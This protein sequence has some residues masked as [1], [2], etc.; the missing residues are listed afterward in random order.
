VRPKR[1]TLFARVPTVLR[2]GRKSHQW[3]T[4]GCHAIRGGLLALLVDLSGATSYDR[5]MHR[6]VDV[7]RVHDL[8]ESHGFRNT[9]LR[10]TFASVWVKDAR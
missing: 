1:S 5:P 6:A 7:H 10:H 4:A 3:R 9:L 2:R 8:I